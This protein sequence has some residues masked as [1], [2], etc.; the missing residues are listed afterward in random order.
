MHAQAA[1]ASAMIA[2]AARKRRDDATRGGRIDARASVRKR[3]ARV[4]RSPGARLLRLLVVL[5]LDGRRRDGRLH[6][7]PDRKVVL[8]HVPRRL[9]ADLPH[10]ARTQPRSRAV[11]SYG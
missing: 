1:V 4:R 7:V 3:R 10:C 9:L 11:A 5:V 6:Q 8:W 2:R